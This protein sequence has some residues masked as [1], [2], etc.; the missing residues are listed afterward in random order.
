MSVSPQCHSTASWKQ[1]EISSRPYLYIFAHYCVLCT[2]C[3]HFSDHFWP[4]RRA[5]RVRFCS[6]F[7]LAIFANFYTICAQFCTKINTFVTIIIIFITRTGGR[8]QET[9]SRVQ[10]TEGEDESSTERSRTEGE[11]APRTGT[12]GMRTLYHVQRG[13]EQGKLTFLI[14]L[15]IS[16]YEE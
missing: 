6:Q 14:L 16:I 13:K 9:S 12:E 1:L 8:S 4:L 10:Q 5:N 2:I 3:Q 11:P 7:V 15:Y